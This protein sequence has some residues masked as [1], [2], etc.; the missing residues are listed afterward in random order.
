MVFSSLE[1]GSKT[2][3]PSDTHWKQ[4]MTLTAAAVK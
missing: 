3:C 2:A 1:V 4:D